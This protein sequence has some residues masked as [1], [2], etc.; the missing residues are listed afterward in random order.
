MIVLPLLGTFVS[1]R[2]ATKCVKDHVIYMWPPSWSKIQKSLIV[3][4]HCSWLGLLS[5]NCPLYNM[6]TSLYKFSRLKTIT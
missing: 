6:W 2:L 3:S 5:L 1:T 4:L